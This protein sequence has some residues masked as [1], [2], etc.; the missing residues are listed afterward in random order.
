[1]IRGQSAFGDDKADAAILEGCGTAVGRSEDS[2]AGYRAGDGRSSNLQLEGDLLFQAPAAGRLRENNTYVVAHLDQAQTIVWLE[3][4]SVITSQALDSRGETGAGPQMNGHGA[5]DAIVGP[6]ACA[7]NKD[8][9][10]AILRD[11]ECRGKV[12][13][14]RADIVDPRVPP[15]SAWLRWSPEA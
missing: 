14:Q 10:A 1:L 15:K 12:L 13:A 4:Q 5:G 9:A 8:S 6:L 11:A 3:Q 2:G 7:M